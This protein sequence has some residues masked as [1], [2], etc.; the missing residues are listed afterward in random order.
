[1]QRGWSIRA[2]SQFLLKITSLSFIGSSNVK[3]R[4][5][6]RTK[7]AAQAGNVTGSVACFVN[8]ED[9]FTL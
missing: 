5:E 4:H 2:V 6:Q 8:I 1:M 9:Y 7:S 3:A